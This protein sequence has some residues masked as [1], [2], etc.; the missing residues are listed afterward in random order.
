LGAP[1]GFWWYN[2]VILHVGP[3]N[4]DLECSPAFGQLPDIGKA[5]ML[6]SELERQI[7]E[8]IAVF[9]Y[10]TGLRVDSIGL[11]DIHFHGSPPQYFVKVGA[12]L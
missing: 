1:L 2:A 10:R 3:V 6:R 9:H 5:K 12:V 11:E 7:G 4:D 8:L